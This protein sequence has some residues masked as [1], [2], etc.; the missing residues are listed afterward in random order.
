[1]ARA[2]AKLSALQKDILLCLLPWAEWLRNSPDCYAACRDHGAPLM[3]I[4]PKGV[5]R[6]DSAA[7]S[8][9]LRRLEARGLII[10]TNSS[11][12]SPEQQGWPRGRVRLRME[13]PAPKRTDHIILTPEGEAVAKRLT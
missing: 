3:R 11:S 9:A 13:E 7:F 1:V 8:R 5:S 12:G 4:R 10:R 2:D 6:A